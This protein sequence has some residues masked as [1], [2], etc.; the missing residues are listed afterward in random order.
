L[1]LY[2]VVLATSSSIAQSIS[3]LVCTNRVWKEGL[4]RSVSINAVAL[5]ALSNLLTW[6]SVVF[7]TPC[8]KSKGHGFEFRCCHFFFF[9]LSN[10]SGRIRPWGLLNL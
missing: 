9:N 2:N 3:P 7:K 8:Y 5:A 10:P 1:N 6:D 4:N